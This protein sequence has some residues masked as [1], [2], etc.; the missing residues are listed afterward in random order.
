[1]APRIHEKY[2]INQEMYEV[3]LKKLFTVSC[4]FSFY[5]LSGDWKWA[6]SA[7]AIQQRYPIPERNSGEDRNVPATE[8]AACSSGVDTEGNVLQ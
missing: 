4:D 6:R 8:E 2:I 5:L 1:M 7:M 3:L